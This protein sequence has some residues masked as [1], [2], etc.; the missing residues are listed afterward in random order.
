MRVGIFGVGVLAM[1][2]GIVIE[3]IYELWYLCADLVYVIL[4]P[5]LVSVIYLDWTNTYGSLAG[6]IIGLLFRLLGG[7]NAFGLSATIHYPGYV[8]PQNETDP[9]TGVTTWTQDSQRYGAY[10]TTRSVY[11]SQHAPNGWLGSLVDRASDLR[12][13]DG[14]F[15]HR[16]PHYRSAGTGISDR[17]WADVPSRYVSSNPGQRSRIP[18]VGRE[19]SSGQSAVMLCGWE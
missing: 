15:D 18:F 5:Q 19:I 8:P 2:M 10:D 7:E 13:D 11:T 16:P 1:V 9:D 6:Y 4:F 17:L 3:S 14:E 12:L